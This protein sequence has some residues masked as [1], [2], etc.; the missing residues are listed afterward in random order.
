MRVQWLS[1]YRKQ[2]ESL[3]RRMVEI[4]ALRVSADSSPTSRMCGKKL[5]AQPYENRAP[6]TVDIYDTAITKT[7]IL[8]AP[9]P[10]FAIAGVTKP[11]TRS[12]TENLS[13]CANRRLKVLKI[14]IETSG[15][16]RPNITPKAM[17]I[18]TLG[19]RPNLNSFHFK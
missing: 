7:S 15:E 17:A 14:R 2:A 10:K 18:T 13:N 9:L 11:S 8:P 19:K 3:V 16:Y 12:G 6:H 1:S 5:L 4:R